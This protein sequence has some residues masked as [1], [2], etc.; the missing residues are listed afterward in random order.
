[1]SWEIRKDIYFNFHVDKYGVPTFKLGVKATMV[2]TRK[3]VYIL[4]KS[5]NGMSTLVFWEVLFG[6]L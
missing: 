2:N 5:S 4:S 1:M 6:F 3:C